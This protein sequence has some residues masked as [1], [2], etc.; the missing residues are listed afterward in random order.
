MIARGA[1]GGTALFRGMYL[2]AIPVPGDGRQAFQPIHVAD[3]AR[4][5]ALALEGSALVRMTVDTVGPQAVVLR[6]ILRDYRH[7]L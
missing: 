4:V 1:F 6:D 3:V 2:P 7:W 5:V